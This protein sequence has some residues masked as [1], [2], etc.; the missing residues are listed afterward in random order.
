MFNE[1]AR[2]I[3]GL[4]ILLILFFAYTKKDKLPK[5]VAYTILGSIALSM[6]FRGFAGLISDVE[7]LN[8]LESIFRTF[9]DLVVFVEILVIL[10]LLFLSKHTTKIM[11]LKTGIIVY[12]VLTVLM[13]LGI[14]K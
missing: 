13:Q 1:I 8:F 12:V 9:A 6:V 7:F 14:F 10:F 4:S 5:Y 11:L 2:I 3:I